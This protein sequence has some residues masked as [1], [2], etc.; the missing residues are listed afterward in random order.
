MASK[1]RSDVMLFRRIAIQRFE[2]ADWLLHDERTT[3]AIYMA[4]YSV[5]CEL[6]ALVLSVVPEHRRKKVLKLFV[7]SKAHD[8]QWLLRLYHQYGGPQIPFE[9]HQ[10]FVNLATWSTNLRYQAG[11]APRRDAEDFLKSVNVVLKWAEGRL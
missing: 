11:T 6:K 7:G 8:F 10:E 1:S 4:G 9:I 3:G 5:E 2:D